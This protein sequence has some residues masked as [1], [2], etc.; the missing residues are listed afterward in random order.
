MFHQY[1][2]RPEIAALMP[3][4]NNMAFSSYN[5]CAD[6]LLTFDL[7]NSVLDIDQIAIISFKRM[8]D[9]GV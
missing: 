9:I 3:K 6:F 2:Y 5:L 8:L 1:I 4:S 7:H